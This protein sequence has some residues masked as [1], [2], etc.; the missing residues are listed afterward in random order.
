MPKE[1]V[2]DPNAFHIV[3]KVNGV[4]TQDG[5]TKN[6]IWTEAH[7]IRFLTSTLTLYPGD[8]SSA[9]RPTASARLELPSS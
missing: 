1:F 2:A 5:N 4:V 3:T 7:M 9:A 8:V 6:L